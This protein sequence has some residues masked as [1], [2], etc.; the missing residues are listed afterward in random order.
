MSDHEVMGIEMADEISAS[1]QFRQTKF[2]GEDLDTSIKVVLLNYGDN[3]RIAYCFNGEWSG[4]KSELVSV[5]GDIP[6]CPNGHVCTEDAS[7]WRLAL[8]KEGT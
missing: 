3:R 8:M 1:I 4:P 2:D 5:D 6:H 7:G